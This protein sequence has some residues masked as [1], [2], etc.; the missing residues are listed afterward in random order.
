MATKTVFAGAWVLALLVV[1]AIRAADPPALL[2]SMDKPAPVAATSP[3]MPPPAGRSPYSPSDWITY[4]HADCCGP[5]GDNGPLGMEV[6]IRTGPSLPFGGELFAP[7]LETG[8]LIQGGVQT[9]FF[10]PDADAAWILDLSVSYMHNSGK[11]DLPGQSF[12]FPE[13]F[14]FGTGTLNEAPT[15]VALRALHRTFFNVGGGREWYLIGSGN[16]GSAPDGSA[17]L[18][19]R[20]GID[21]GARYGIARLDLMEANQPDV[22]HRRSHVISAA[23]AALHTDVEIPCGCCTFLAGFRAEW[24]YTWMNLVSNFNNDLQDVNLLLT[25]GVRF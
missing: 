21:G 12:V 19:W 11:G 8:W 2:S 9:L 6:Y 1:C 14:G 24:D 20:V 23:F 22:F 18:N 4:H 17:G 25:A 5:L 13:L 7:R 3:D 10:N 16:N 15:E